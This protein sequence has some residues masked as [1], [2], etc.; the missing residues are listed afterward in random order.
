ME[1]QYPNRLFHCTPSWVEDGCVFHIRIRCALENTVVLSQPLIASRLLESVEFYTKKGRWFVH[2]FLLMPD[3][4]HALVSFPKEQE[5]SRVIAD[6]KR[7]YC[8]QHGIR[9]QDNFFD[10]RIRNTTEYLGKA[11]YIRNNPVAAGLC[12]TPAEWVPVFERT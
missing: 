2:L 5:M 3:H 1:K 8:K 7:Y 9:W 11:T 10:H 12:E 4:L 6:W